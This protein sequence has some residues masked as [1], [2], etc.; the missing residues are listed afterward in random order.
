MSSKVLNDMLHQ[1]DDD[2]KT[3]PNDR[4]CE[5]KFEQLEKNPKEHIKSIM[6]FR[7]CS[8]ENMVKMYNGIYNGKRI[9][10]TGHTGFKGSWMALVLQKLGATVI[11]YSLPP[12]TKPSHYSLLN[13]NLN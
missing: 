4:Y 13:L 2:F 7:N 1:I 6:E 10:L 12:N 9:L 3:L 11:G 5:I 8:V